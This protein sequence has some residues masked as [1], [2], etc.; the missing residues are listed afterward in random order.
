MD[1]AGDL[2]AAGYFSGSSA[3]F[4]G[5]VLT[6]AGSEDAV[7]WKTSGEGT[8]L[9]VVRGGGTGDDALQSVTTDGANAVVAAGSFKSSTATFGGLM[10]TNAG[11]RDIVVWKMSDEGTTLWA[12]RGGGSG[13]DWFWRGGVCVD[14]FG[15]VMTAGTA[16]SSK[17]TFG[18]VVLTI[19]GAGK[20]ILWK[21]SGE[22]TTLWAMS[23]GDAYRSYMD[24][25]V[26]DSANAVIAAGH[27][28]ANAGNSVAWGGVAL[29]AAGID[30]AVLWKLSGEGTTLWVVRGG[31]TGVDRMYAVDV[32]SVNAVVAA[33]WFW[34]SEATFGGVAM[35]NFGGDDAVVWKLSA[36]GT[37]LWVVHQGGTGDEEAFGVVVDGANAVVVSL[38]SSSTPFAGEA[39]TDAG[40][41]DAVLWK[42]SAEGTTL[43]TVRG[44][45]SSNDYMHAVAVDGTNAVV[46]AGYFS[47]STATFGGVELTTAGSEDALVWKVSD[48]FFSLTRIKQCCARH[49]HPLTIA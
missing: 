18:G 26:V 21:M 41:R 3:T 4:G 34:S 39:Q 7:V 42:L 11:S 24:A 13:D 6:S 32:D 43:W 19:T 12:V 33:G 38:F 2:V 28:W 37:T 20:A 5:V 15:A 22:G 35:T 25:V 1:G 23:G 47:S 40:G 8:T 9:W 10:L 31:G 27:L 44:G 36:E 49:C 14:N 48:V 29:T 16:F 46:A 45:G 30:D 17:A